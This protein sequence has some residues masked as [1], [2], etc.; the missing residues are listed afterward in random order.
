MVGLIALV[1]ALAA[2]VFFAGARRSVGERESRQARVDAALAAGGRA[3]LAHDVAAWDAA[4]PAGRASTR[5]S[6]R[7]VFASLSRYSWAGLQF[8]AEPVDDVQR[9]YGVT[10]RGRLRGSNAWT[11]VYVC[12]L[13]LRWS[14]DRVSLRMNVTPFDRRR[15]RF[16][17]FTH[18]LVM[19]RDHIIVVGERRQKALMSRIAA[20]DDQAE[21]VIRR[22]RLDPQ[23]ADV[24][25]VTTVFVCSSRLQAAR[26]SAS[27]KTDAETSAFE[28]SGSIYFI[29]P[30]LSGWRSTLGSVLRHELAHRYAPRFGDG[31]HHVGLL[32]EG[33]AVAVQG[34]YGY[35]VVQSQLRRGR[36]A[37]PLIKA[38]AQENIQ[39]GRTR[40][41]I[42]LAYEEGGTL[43]E[44]IW[45]RWGLERL[46]RFADTVAASDMTPAGIRHATRE[47]L[48]VGWKQ[49]ESGWERFVPT[50][51]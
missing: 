13:S 27:R 24:K 9:V 36:L 29:A 31:K 37:L 47:T 42:E 6:W 38:L 8:K 16:L 23:A 17:A 34:D 51:K 28:T 5:R 20:R 1:A 12:A 30:Q 41:E 44:Y 25:H 50:A 33:L 19:R 35:E 10:V 45:K 48:G 32:I 3:I 4:L 22:L 39:K 43:V 2:V 18:P 21:V 46:R 14:S 49:L 26:A 7:K 40:H 11:T 15:D